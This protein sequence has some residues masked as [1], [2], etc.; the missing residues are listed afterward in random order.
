M[1]FPKDLLDVE[2]QDPEES[3]N[4]VRI[5]NLLQQGSYDNLEDVK[6]G[7]IVKYNNIL[8]DLTCNSILR[9]DEAIEVLLGEQSYMWAQEYANCPLWCIEHWGWECI[10]K[11]TYDQAVNSIKS[12]NLLGV[13]NISDIFDEPIYPEQ[14]RT[15][16]YVKLRDILLWAVEEG[17]SISPSLKTAL[18]IFV[19]IKSKFHKKTI[20]LEAAFQ[21]LFYL[22]PDAKAST[23][24]DDPIIEQICGRPYGE[25]TLHDIARRVDPRPDGAKTAK[26]TSGINPYPPVPIPGTIDTDSN[27]LLY[28]IKNLKIINLEI[29]KIFREKT[30]SIS[31]QE[32]IS[33][34]LVRLY[35]MEDGHK[36]MQEMAHHW[37]S[38]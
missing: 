1:L 29:V 23:L 32:I 9:L 13:I 22:H 37:I 18:R 14:K 4:F 17:I 7:F 30:P 25:K 10:A 35:L 33:H 21:T 5:S 31:F 27:G 20:Q 12:K 28:N 15:R 6:K 3:P 36:I 19:P 26:K 11:T 34:P 16:Y 38:F 24:I 2:N 8:S